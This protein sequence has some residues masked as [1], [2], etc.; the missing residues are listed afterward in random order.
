M[1]IIKYYRII[2]SSVH[3]GIAGDEYGNINVIMKGVTASKLI[4]SILQSFLLSVIVK[5]FLAHVLKTGSDF[6]DA[7][8][9]FVYLI[10]FNLSLLFL[11]F[12]K[13]EIV[14]VKHFRFI[15]IIFTLVCIFLPVCL[16]IIS[17]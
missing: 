16:I 5:I 1:V 8:F 13:F 10:I 7:L 9:P 2:L 11:C 15:A 12:R 3:L 14:K 4:I 6:N 17:K